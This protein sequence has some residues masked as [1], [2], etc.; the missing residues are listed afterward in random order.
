MDNDVDMGAGI[1][2]LLCFAPGYI[3]VFSFLCLSLHSA[4][5]ALVY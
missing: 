5:M 1:L 4:C 2:L 3:F